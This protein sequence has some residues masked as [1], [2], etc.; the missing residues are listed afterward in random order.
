MLPRMCAA[1]V[2]RGSVN[3]SVFQGISNNSKS[4]RSAE[5]LWQNVVKAP[6]E[7]WR[8]SRRFGKIMPWRLRAYARLGIFRGSHLLFIIC[9]NLCYSVDSA[10]SVFPYDD[11]H[12]FVFAPPWRHPPNLSITANLVNPMGPGANCSA[13]L[14]SP[15][16]VLYSEN[17]D[18]CEWSRYLWMF[19]E[20]PLHGFRDFR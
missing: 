8:I 19:P 11:A 1:V 20:K 12:A 7:Y 2:F 10:F 6:Q 18:R 9:K 13:V 16:S 15:E 14:L 4:C 17:A 3:Y 5:D